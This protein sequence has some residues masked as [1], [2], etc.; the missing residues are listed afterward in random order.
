MAKRR[1][2]GEIYRVSLGSAGSLPRAQSHRSVLCKHA[3]LT[4]RA[5]S[6]MG[7]MG[8]FGGWDGMGWGTAHL[9]IKAPRD[10]SHHKQSGMLIVV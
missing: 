5:R 8:G 9:H 10:A 6:R 4:L 2:D 1:S 7:E 3:R